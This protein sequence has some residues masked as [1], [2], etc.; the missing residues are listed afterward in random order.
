M[1]NFFSSDFLQRDRII[2]APQCEG[3]GIVA[4][5]LRE[6]FCG[7]C[8]KKSSRPQSNAI[9]Q[10]P[11]PA[12]PATTASKASTPSDVS[13]LSPIDHSTPIATQGY[14][15]GRA[16]IMRSIT[17]K[18]AKIA[19]HRAIIREAAAIAIHTTLVTV[20]HME[21]NV[22]G[23]KNGKLFLAPRLLAD[24]ETKLHKVDDGMCLE[25]FIVNTVNDMNK[26]W[27]LTH[28]VP[29]QL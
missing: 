29:L 9:Q 4:M 11:L 20:T 14:F 28:E 5:F 25:N 24:Y 13:T 2:A 16:Q 22:L 23:G 7:V 27:A 15:R 21:Q 8:K 6:Q 18:G 10:T 1:T 3:C 26:Q 12:T 19:N 17:D